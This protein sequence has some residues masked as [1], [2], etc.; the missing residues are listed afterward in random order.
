MK[1]R[2]IAIIAVQAIAL[3]LCGCGTATTQQSSNTENQSVE[4]QTQPI[5]ES[6]ENTDAE[7]N[8]V[9]E[10]T[11]ET[12]EAGNT[13]ENGVYISL[14]GDYKFYPC[15]G[16]TPDEL[17]K[18]IAGL[19]D[20]DLSLADEITTGKGGMTVSFS[21]EACLF[22]GP[23]E[24]QKD[25]FYVT[26]DYQLTFAVLDSIQKTLQ[27]WA[28]PTNPDSVDIYFCMEGDVPLELEKIGVT[29]PMEE[30]YSHEALEKLLGQY[31]Q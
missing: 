7:E 25:E 4:T 21:K 17:V 1:K 29:L 19:T 5:G 30:P 18:N 27:S 3:A 31:N 16:S 10:D 15:D 13:E 22:T 28:N 6:E 26:D 14:G 12:A 11:T 24:E 23:P 9:V 20:W 2:I 8:T